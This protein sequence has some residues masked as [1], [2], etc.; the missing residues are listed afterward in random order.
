ME[1]KKPNA[2]TMKPDIGDFLK[3]ANNDIKKKRGGKAARKVDIS[4]GS[5]SLFHQIFTKP[6]NQ[7]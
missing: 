7:S 3:K 4:K 1:T 6:K 2:F 5:E